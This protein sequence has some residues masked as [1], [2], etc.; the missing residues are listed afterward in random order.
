MNVQVEDKTVYKSN[1]YGTNRWSCTIQPGRNDKN[2]II[3][4]LEQQKIAER[5]A[6]LINTYG[7]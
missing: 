1:A 7:L 6:Y 5:I 4:E 2:E 3:N